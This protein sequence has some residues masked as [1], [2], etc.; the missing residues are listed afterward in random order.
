MSTRVE[1]TQAQR[2]QIALGRFVRVSVPAGSLLVGC[3][4]GSWRA[5]QNECRHRALPLDLGATSPMSDDGEYLLC[6]Q[7]G[8]MY[9]RGDGV[10][11]AGPCFG[12]RLT[13]V[14]VEDREGELLLG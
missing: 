5:Y 8:A 12:A 13:P 14:D 4:G 7:H 1:L 2:T 10:C 3:V 6:H 11:V 9:R